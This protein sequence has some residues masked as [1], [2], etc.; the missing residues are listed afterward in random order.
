VVFQFLEQ[1]TQTAPASAAV[2]R[3]LHRVPPR[4]AAEGATLPQRDL[5]L[6]D[7]PEAVLIA[8][9]QRLTTYVNTAFEMLTG[10]RSDEVIGRS[11][12]LL[13]GPDTCEVSVAAMREALDVGRPFKG[14]LL[15]YRK[16]GKPFWN[17]LTVVPVYDLDGLLIQF[18]GTQR[19]VSARRDEHAQVMLAARLFE[20]GSEGFI[21]ADAAGRIIKVNRAFT[22][23]SGY[24]QADAL[25][26]NPGMLSSGLHDSEFYQAMWHCVRDSGS[27]Q[28]E[29]WNRRKDGTIYPQQMTL[30]RITNGMG[31][32]T[33]YIA[34]FSDITERKSAL[35]SI[36]RLAHYDTLTGLPNR[37]FLLDRANQALSMAK[38]GGETVAVL[39][40]DLDHFKNVNDSLGHPLGDK[41]LVA[42]AT[43]LTASLREQD[44]LSR[45]GG[46]EFVLLLPN[47][48][49]SGAAH[50]VGKL[51]EATGLPFQI[52]QHELTVTP[53]I[54]I[55][56][57]PSDGADFETLATCADVAMY[58]AKDSGRNA[59]CFFTAEMQAQSVRMLLLENALRRAVDRGELFLHYQPQCSLHDGSIVGAEALLR[60]THPDL[61]SVSP[62]EFI[63]IAESSGLITP[64]GEWVLRSALTQ[65]RLWDEAGIAPPVIAVN[66]SAVQ[67]RQ[68]GF[69]GIVSRLLL[70]CGVAPQRLE[71]ELTESVASDDSMGAMAV[72]SLLHEAGVRMSIDDFGTGYSSL[73]YLKRFKVGKLKIDR[74]FVSNVTQDIDDQAIVTAIISLAHSLGMATV[75]EGVETLEQMEY[76][77]A[78]GCDELQGYWFARPMPADGFDA[79]MRARVQSTSR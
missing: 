48:D 12:A 47:T 2:T 77:R 10:F 54:G 44:T 43:R 6:R 39:F 21:I 40:L 64:I 1:D 57:Y 13:Q 7:A 8:N 14:E 35:D 50:V 59:F 62:S 19:D 9:N 27:W 72:M 55:A 16:D 60:W 68:A 67:F 22:A 23:I 45:V 11:C 42:M 41:L 76:L 73:S 18:I 3:P 63:P 79:F 28:G 66:L 51:L 31:D 37:T 33:H 17:E 20:H 52:D 69:P 49:A 15:N 30:R 46:D 25:G 65:M 61:G 75:A 34:S 36:W 29:I 53:S 26:R 38:R 71:L 58:R 32:V 5:A 24:S 74:S 78:R 70:E 4:H 56:M